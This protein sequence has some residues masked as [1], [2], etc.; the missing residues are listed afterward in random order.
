MRVRR[1]RGNVAEDFFER[2]FGVAPRTV[3]RLVATVAGGGATEGDLYFEHAVSEALTLEDGI[4]RA[5]SRSVTQGMGCRCVKDLEMGY[6]FTE[7]FDPEALAETAR[8]ARAIADRAQDVGPVPVRRSGAPD[9][10]LYETLSMEAFGAPEERVRLL[11]AVDAAARGFDPRVVQV[12]AVLSCQ[13]KYV[14]IVDVQ[15]RLATDVRPLVRLMVSCVARDGTS[16]ETGYDGG[17]GRFGLSALTAG[18]GHLRYAREAARLAVQNLSAAPAPAGEMTVVLGPGSPGI[19]LHEAIGHGLEAD[20]NRKGTSAFSGRI[21]Q[22]VASPLCTVVDD[23]TVPQARGSLHQDDEGT[24]TGRTVLIEKGV[25]RGYLQDRQNARL[26]GMPVTGNARREDFTFAPMPRMTSTFM[27]PGED[28][29]ADIVRSVDRGVYFAR[30]GSGQVDITNGN[31]VFS[32]SEAHLI[33]GGR[34]TRPV[35]NVTLV[36]NGPRVLTRVSRV[37]NDLALDAGLGTC[38]K[39][40][41]GVPVNTGLPTIRVDGMT[42]GGTAR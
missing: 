4:V 38:G 22:K 29:P 16:R 5:A 30:F 13:V 34:I 6:A 1:K 23:G 18:D 11:Q 9:G 19:L 24:P 17:G 26:L 31:F 10:A 35:K 33:E 14:Q 2:R 28:D 8:V 12:I 27:M 41:Q 15:G 36:G 37:G 3:E 7:S 21:G 39:D 32:S 20:F 42:V 40:G 25:L